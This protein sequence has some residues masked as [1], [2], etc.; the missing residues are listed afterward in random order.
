MGDRVADTGRRCS[1]VVVAVG[2]VAGLFIAAQQ[3][4]AA[5]NTSDPAITAYPISRPDAP[6]PLINDVLP[7]PNG[8]VW[9]TW[10]DGTSLSGIGTV[11][12]SGHTA[13]FAAPSGWTVIHATT[14]N[15]SLWATESHAGSQYIVQWAA[16][17]QISATFPVTGAGAL[18][19]ITWG[20]DGALWFAAGASADSCG[21][22][23]GLIGR[24]TTAG[25]LTTF[26]LPTAGAGDN[27]AED[28]TSA[29]DGALWFDLPQQGSVGRLT[30]SGTM[31][32]FKLPSAQSQC[33]FVADQD[34]AAASNGAMWVG[35]YWSGGIQQVT[36]DGQVTTVPARSNLFSVATDSAGVL[37]LTSAFGGASAS[38]LSPGDG[39]G[40]NSW[41]LP[42]AY[43]AGAP[44]ITI[45]PD[46]EPWIGMQGVIERLDP[47]VPAAGPTATPTPVATP[48]VSTP[49]AGAVTTPAP[50]N[51]ESDNP[52]PSPGTGTLASAPTHPST[53]SGLGIVLGSIAGVVLLA[54]GAAAIVVRRRHTTATKTPPTP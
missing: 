53:G 11:Y 29:S 32:V 13:T 41:P 8:G 23:S 4:A 18:R 33:D 28:I 43:P 47:S 31:S 48:T 40:P 9:F 3:N 39:P 50:F 21:M 52:S 49:A 26:A 42:P 44:L 35:T 27:G 2:A 46:G 16:S 36:P 24:M 51:P 10:S 7:G 20:P 45:G 6:K 54:S 17:G 15:G 25:S 19:G 1:A 37:W 34:L 12:S 5:S 38:R 14:G 30:T 22:Q